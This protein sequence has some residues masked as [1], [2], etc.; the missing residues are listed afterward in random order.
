[1]RVVAEGVEDR[2]TLLLLA[3]LGCDEIQGYFVSKPLTADNF[4]VWLKNEDEFE[5]RF[6]A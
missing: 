6:A 3:T 4:V 5:L 1:L 2:A